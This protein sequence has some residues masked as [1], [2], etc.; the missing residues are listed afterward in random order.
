MVRIRLKRTG[1]R[2]QPSYRLTAVDGRSTRDGRVL[3]E[4]GFYDPAHRSPE[5]QC[6]LKTERIEY[7][8]RVG[9]QPS[10]TARSL[11]KKAGIAVGGRKK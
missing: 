11:L 3:E 5:L 8:L 2:H 4:L 6:N 7:W 10:E 1:R 9:A